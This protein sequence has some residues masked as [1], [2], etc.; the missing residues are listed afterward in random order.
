MFLARLRHFALFAA[1]LFIAG[2]LGYN[3]GRRV[4]NPLVS[5]VYPRDL[6]LFW[7]VWDKLAADYLDKQA[8]DDD[9]LVNGA[10]KGLVASLGDPY[11]VYL[12]SA[13]NKQAKED[14][15]GRF[16]GVGLQLDYN[17][18][19]QVIVVA[20]LPNTPAEKAGIK[21]GDL[22]LKVDEQIV[23]NFSLPE[24]VKLIRGP[25]GTRVKLT[26]SRAG[27]TD[28]FE[29]D[30]ERS[31]V[32][33]ASVELVFQSDLA[34]LKLVR[35]GDQIEREWYRAVD[36]IVSRRPRGVVLD[37]RNNPGG[38][39]SGAVFVASEFLSSGVV[40]YQESQT[41]SRESYQVNRQGRLTTIPLVVLL[42]PGSASA[43]EIVAGALQAHHRA[44][45]IGEKSFGKGT[46]QES[47]DF[48]DGAGLHITIARWLTPT[49]QSIDKQGIRPDLEVKN[50]QDAPTQDLQFAKAVEVLLK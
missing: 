27:L 26:L 42:N 35:F 47:E 32:L 18:T 43:S 22:I 48:P 41:G 23:D 33:V 39:L 13:E 36:Q 50:N 10:I 24:V 46:V 2:A 21:A 30:L 8:L 28:F 14:L 38:Y 34:H 25:K 37:L 12:S 3:L 44:K 5:V 6:G 49:G 19:N 31:T 40:V 17:Q 29:V 1:F 15:N 4:A 9:N 7:T 20:P 16:D 11:T 45:V